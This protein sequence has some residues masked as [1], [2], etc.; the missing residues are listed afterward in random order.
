MIT[1]KSGENDYY[2]EYTDGENVGHC[3]APESLGGGGEGFTPFSL[4]EASLACC[5]NMTLR[6]YAK[7]H[8]IQLDEVST[9]VSITREVDG[10]SVECTVSVPESLAPGQRKRL[11]AAARGCPIHSV[12]AKPASFVIKEG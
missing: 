5:M 4:L 11:L 8:C 12:L 1:S 9:T 2:T 6:I 10:A 3:D 7:N